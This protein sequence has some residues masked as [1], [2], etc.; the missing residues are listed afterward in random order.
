MDAT[1]LTLG[2]EFSGYAMQ[3]ENGIKAIEKALP[4]ISEIA[5]GGTAV[6]TDLN[7]DPKYANRVAEVISEL[8]GFL[9]ASAP[10]K[11]EALA[12]NDAV[13]EMS[14]ALRRLACS[15]MKI[16]NDIRMLASGPR[17]GIG[18]IR[19]PANEPDS[20]IMPGKINPTQCEAMTMVAAQ[21][22]GNDTAIAIGGSLGQFEL[23]VFKPLMIYNLL[24]SMQLLGD[25]AR[26]FTEK[27]ANGI[28]PNK[29]RI[30]YHLQNSLM[31]AT[32]LNTKIGYDKAS[33]IVKK[34]YEENKT[35]KAA[36]LELNLL[37][38]K[39]FDDIVDPN[40]MVNLTD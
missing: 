14:G 12:V 24:S 19:L 28:E 37:S 33:Q 4:T 30:A 21:V 25:V 32:A 7:T 15:Y 36:A 29:E 18:E 35:L 40:K 23:N 31:L 11:F 3:I 1:P 8:T 39:E 17:C 6:G 20:S 9:F 2:Q 13:V 10:N 22:M 38:E 5:L 26:N 16:G 34:A 27:C